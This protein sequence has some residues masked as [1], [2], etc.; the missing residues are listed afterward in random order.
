[1]SEAIVVG[2]DGSKAARVS[3]PARGNALIVA[4]RERRGA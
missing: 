3:P 2:I 4:T 1:M